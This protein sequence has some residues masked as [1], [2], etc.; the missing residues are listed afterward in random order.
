[1]LQDVGCCQYALHDGSSDSESPANLQDAYALDPEL[2]YAR[3]YRRFDRTTTQ[4][5][6]ALLDPGKARIDPLADHAALEFSKDWSCGNVRVGIVRAG[7]T[8]PAVCAL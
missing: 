5:D 3:L 6:A 8:A 2:L 4:P 7:G 1:L